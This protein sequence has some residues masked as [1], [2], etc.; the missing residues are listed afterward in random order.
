MS[1]YTELYQ[2]YKE[3]GICT[4][5]GSEKAVAGKT[6]CLICLN[7]SNERSKSYYHNRMTNE[8]KE[9]RRIRN[10]RRRNL[11]IA[12]GICRNCLKKDATNGQFCLEC[13]LKNRARNEK[14]REKRQLISRSERIA[15]GQC[16]FCGKPVTTG[17]KTC[18]ECLSIR[19][20]AINIHKFNNQNHNWRT[21]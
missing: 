21:Y 8:Q 12:F 14:A 9:R 7:D 17:K 3:K 18:S 4:K 6:M 15:N 10:N 5:C 2:W 16:Y 20:Q 19:Q 1:R 11:C 13:Y